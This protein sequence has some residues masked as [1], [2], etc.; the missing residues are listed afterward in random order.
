MSGVYVRLHNHIFWIVLDNSPL[1]TLTIEMLSQINMVLR[2]AIS[3]SPTLL[4][5]TGAGE[6]AFCAGVELSDDTDTQRTAL[7]HTAQDVCTAFAELRT[8]GISTIALVKGIA[9]GAGCELVS[10]CDTVIAREDAR[11]RL[12]PVNA[13]VFADATTTYLPAAIGQEATTRYIQS[14]ETIDARTALSLGL[15]H[16]VL[17]AHRFLTDTEE[18]LVMLSAHA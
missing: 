8:H 2:R 17:P 15:A 9:F 3:Q 7:L 16:Q 18:L 11:F 12:P 13:K 10:L 4:V 5:I 14:G 6:R 1:N